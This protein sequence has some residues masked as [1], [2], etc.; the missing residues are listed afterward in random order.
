[1]D[2]V[3]SRIIPTRG[4]ERN[5]IWDVVR[6][7]TLGQI[8]FYGT[9][10]TVAIAAIP[11]GTVEVWQ[12]ALIVS[13]LACLAFVRIADGLSRGGLKIAEPVLLAP[14]VAVPVFAGIQL[15]PLPIT[16]LT[17]SVDPY[18]TRIFIFVFGSLIVCA[19]ILFAYTN[20]I[21]RL[22][23]LTGLIF[24]VALGSA[25][26]GALW[27]LLD[28]SGPNFLA[29]Y[30]RPHQGYAQFINRNHFAVM[31]EM[32]VGLLI[33]L[34]LRGEFSEK[35]R[36]L[37]WVATGF[38]IYSLVAASSR[39]GLVSLAGMAVFAVFLHVFTKR[40][41]PTE[42]GR[43]RR[44]LFGRFGVPPVLRKLIAAT[45]I[46]VLVTGFVV[47]TI[48]FVGGDQLVSRFEKVETEVAVQET[49]LTNRNI[50][51]ASTLDLIAERPFLG[52]GF[53]AYK[54][55]ITKF[56]R[57]NGNATLAQAHNDYLEILAN[58]GIVGAILFAAFAGLV[59][60]RFAGNL[61]RAVDRER[62]AYT[63]GALVGIF[64]VMVHNLVDFGLHVMVN[65]L[66]F[67]ALI[68]I[69]AARIGTKRTA[70]YIEPGIA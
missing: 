21:S 9:L 12:K 65:A 23:V 68:V 13:L 53:G 4:E 25:L 7:M 31:A 33:G 22:K 32:A 30:V 8:A 3:E 35:I 54:T 18:E 39:G 52:A 28:S 36:F 47:L 59:L 20:S 11:N 43:R 45:V 29:F 56:D 49:T 34:L 67:I 57:T 19:E 42:E 44:S 58:G 51:W 40:S 66:V 41:E 63:F 48:A 55:A 5:R 64:G 6:G 50:I 60:Y 26:F 1:M 62:A 17:I 37:G 10:L 69:G 2:A 24:T 16:G 38:L 70:S 27:E 15:A 14:L 61:G 46:G